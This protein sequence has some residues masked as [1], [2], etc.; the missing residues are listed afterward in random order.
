MSLVVRTGPATFCVR[1]MARFK[2]IGWAGHA[3][4]GCTNRNGEEIECPDEATVFRLL[5]WPYIEPEERA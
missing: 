5:G 2:A 3:Y 1:M 4:A